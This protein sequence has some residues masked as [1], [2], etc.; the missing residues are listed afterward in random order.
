MVDPAIRRILVPAMTKG[1]QPSLMDQVRVVET[2]AAVVEMEMV[3]VTAT[4]T[5]TATA[6][7]RE[8]G[9]I[10]SLEL[11]ELHEY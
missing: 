6:T 7:E 4:A 3:T 11:C 8:K 2:V 9:I 1:I 10:E 5:A